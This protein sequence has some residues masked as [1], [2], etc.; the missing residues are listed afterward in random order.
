MQQDLYSILCVYIVKLS[1][2]ILVIYLRIYF[3]YMFIPLLNYIFKANFVI[4]T[5]LHLF[6]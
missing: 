2:K 6:A 1:V 3:L 5:P 4:S